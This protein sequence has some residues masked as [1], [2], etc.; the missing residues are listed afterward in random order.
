MKNPNY[1]CQIVASVI[2]ASINYGSI[3]R[4]FKSREEQKRFKPK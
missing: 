1:I 4:V 2:L 3:W